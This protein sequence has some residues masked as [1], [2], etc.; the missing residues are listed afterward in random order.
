MPR[1][2]SKRALVTS[3]EA[4]LKAAEAAAA[5][6]ADGR[7]AQAEHA[8]SAPSSDLSSRKKK[9]E[10]LRPV[11]SPAHIL[12]LA[13]ALSASSVYMSSDQCDSLAVVIRGRNDSDNS[14][15]VYADYVAAC[16]HAGILPYAAKTAY[17]RISKVLTAAEKD[18]EAAMAGCGSGT[19]PDVPEF[20]R[21]ILDLVAVRGRS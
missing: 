6:A 17:D 7:I 14:T 18:L 5:S 16:D 2:V 10:P 11:P 9:K 19:V 13:K 8:E 4:E 3:F 21:L 1:H 20:K 12:Y 15:P